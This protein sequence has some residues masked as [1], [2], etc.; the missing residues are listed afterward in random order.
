MDFE[1]EIKQLK[2]RIDALEKLLQQQHATR[3]IHKSP[4]PYAPNSED[5]FMQ[6]RK[7]NP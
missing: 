1:E 6:E 4:Y 3:S 2:Q 5:W 7:G